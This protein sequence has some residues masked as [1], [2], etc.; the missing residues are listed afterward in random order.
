VQQARG[1]LAAREHH[2]GA[3]QA[4][5][6]RLGADDQTACRDTLASLRALGAAA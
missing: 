6:E 1:D 5:F 4:S 2:V 3:A